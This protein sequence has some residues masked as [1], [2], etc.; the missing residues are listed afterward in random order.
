MYVQFI[1][2]CGAIN[3]AHVLGA[4]VVKSF[5]E[6]LQKIS[7]EKCPY[8]QKLKA[9]D[10]ES[11][12]LKNCNYGEPFDKGPLDEKI[13]NYV[14]CLM[15]YSVFDNLCDTLNGS[16]AHPEELLVSE[17]IIED[18]IKNTTAK[19]ACGSLGRIDGTALS[20]MPYLADFKNS[21]TCQRLCTDYRTTRKICILSSFIWNYTA[22]LQK[23]KILPSASSSNDSQESTSVSDN[24]TVKDNNKKP[25][26]D[27]N[28]KPLPPVN[29][30]QPMPKD[31]VDSKIVNKNTKDESNNGSVIKNEQAVDEKV[32]DSVSKNAVNEKVTG[33]LRPTSKPEPTVGAVLLQPIQKVEPISPQK[34]A[35][36]SKDNANNEQAQNANNNNNFEDPDDAQSVYNGEDDE[37]ANEVVEKPDKVEAKQSDAVAHPMEPVDT[38]KELPPKSSEVKSKIVEVPKPKEIIEEN[39]IT[40]A[41]YQNQN[42]DDSDSYFFSYFMMICVIFVC[43]YVAYH[44][45][46]KILAL[47]LEGRKGKR[48]TR[49][50]RPNSANY[51]KLDTTLEEA[52]TSSCNKNTTQVIY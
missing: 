33:E 38:D 37:F 31:Q 44:N 20:K 52:V 11:D 27:T 43:G 5:Y 50:K 12:F 24:L 14:L 9:I 29:T 39:L 8:V 30:I 41:N 1:L 13:E 2:L 46:Q 35:Q 15:Y 22:M 42:I 10:T 45:K 16:T 51:R 26:S 3:V 21:T 49:G 36:P 34:E 47:V 18:F 25:N 6:Q 32:S 7:Q 48:H 28:N 40:S 17:K 23:K 4:P 19:M